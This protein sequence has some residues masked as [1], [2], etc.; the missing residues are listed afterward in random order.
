[1]ST[2]T[3]S[4]KM[5]DP[6]H[7]DT[8]KAEPTA[9]PSKHITLQSLLQEQRKTLNSKMPRRIKEENTSTQI[10]IALRGCIG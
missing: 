1:M 9:F 4:Q 10:F 2:G 6:E 8:D 7:C 5:L 3:L